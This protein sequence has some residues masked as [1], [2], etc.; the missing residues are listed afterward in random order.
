MLKVLGLQHTDTVRFLMVVKIVG[1]LTLIVD[2]S[3]YLN[4]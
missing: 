4:S 2:L 1:L 3:A